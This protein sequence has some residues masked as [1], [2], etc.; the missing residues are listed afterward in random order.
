MPSN[1]LESLVAK[2]EPLH[3][4]NAALQASEQR[5]RTLFESIGEAMFILDGDRFIDCNQRAMELFGTDRKDLLRSS[6]RDF[7]PKTQP[8]GYESADEAQTR[9]GAALKGGVQKF[10]W[11]HTRKN[12]QP[13]PAAV[14]LTRIH[15]DN[16][17]FVMAIVRDIT[18]RKRAETE[19]RERLSE[20]ER[21]S[22][23]AAERELR[24]I[25]VKRQANDLAEK[26]ALTPPYP[27]V[28]AGVP[29]QDNPSPVTP[30]PIDSLSGQLYTIDQLID[31]QELQ[32]LMELLYRATGIN[33]ALIDNDGKVFTAAGWQRICTHFHR[34]NPITC[35]QC[36]KSDQYVTEHLH[37]GPYV[38]YRCAHGLTDYAVPIMIEG[39]HLA[40]L[41]TG[42]MFHEP[43]DLEFFRKQAAQYGF[44]EEDY[45]RAVKEVHIVPKDS[46]GSVMAFL[47]TMAQ[48]LAKSG[49]ARLR[50]LKDGQRRDRDLRRQ[51]E[52]A[53]NLVEEANEARQ[54]L[55]RSEAKLRLLLDSTAEAIYGTDAAGHCTFCNPACIT[56]LGYSRPEDLLGKDM[57]NLIHDARPDGTPLPLEECQLDH[58]FRSGKGRYLDDEWFRRADGTFFA[59]E[60]RIEPQLENGAM[61]GAVVAFSDI[62]ARRKAED[63]SRRQLNELRQWYTTTLNR[64]N[65]VM[66]LKQEVN[67]L[68]A[69]LGAKP[70]YES[71]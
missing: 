54:S 32:K 31:I 3:N 38:G 70:K 65:R 36:I 18:D 40:N 22:R 23:L 53:L 35:A 30:E 8:D 55:H 28:D 60:C 26:A 14:T 44:D 7:S 1:D 61:T 4:I 64:E 68:L 49:L 41:F 37:E 16:R 13:F 51:R 12:G 45:L 42:Q 34:V 58:A 17:L 57:H 5:Y 9:I 67:S 19:L 2:T 29:V 20:L 71:A 56:L 47:T 62:T 59:A 69:R 10:E 63:E 50:E 25:E 52:A 27:R 21:F 6:V 11:L 24:L 39:R 48:M 15:I 43:P 33:H 46:M 66:E